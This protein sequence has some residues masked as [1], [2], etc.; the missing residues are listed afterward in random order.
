MTK[1][2]PSQGKRHTRIHTACPRCGKHSF[3]I[4]KHKCASCS[5]PARRMKKKNF[6]EKALRRRTTGTGRRAHLKLVNRR[7]HNGFKP[8]KRE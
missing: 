8:L 1:G 6:L 7:F 4:Q 5:F 3:H 2:T